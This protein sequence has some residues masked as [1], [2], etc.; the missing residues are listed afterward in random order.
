ML[1]M[2][3][4]PDVIML[5]EELDAIMQPYLGVKRYGFLRKSAD[6]WGY[7]DN[8]FGGRETYLW[9]AV[10]ET[11]FGSSS[12]AV[13]ACDP[14]TQ[15]CNIDLNRPPF[16][17]QD[18][19]LRGFR[20]HIESIPEERMRKSEEILKKMIVAQRMKGYKAKLED[21][22]DGDEIAFLRAKEREYHGGK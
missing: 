4:P 6:M 7:P 10:Y 11:A 13:F 17:P 8:V 12:I 5:S 15:L 14:S 16:M 22:Y 19:A 18:A 2:G 20:R 9:N 21:M 1:G 3:L